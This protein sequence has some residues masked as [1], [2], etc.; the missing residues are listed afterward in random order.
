V[1][2]VAHRW[3]RKSSDES[4]VETSA[5]LNDVLAGLSQAQ[6]PHLFSHLEPVNLPKGKILYE[7]AEPITSVLFVLSGMISLMAT[8]VDG[9]ST[10]VAAV[11]KEGVVGASAI[12]R[13]EKAPYQISVQVQGFGLRVRSEV[14]N[15]EFD[16]GGPLRERLL[17]YIHSLISEISQSAAC[18]RFHSVDQR[19]CRWLLTYADRLGSNSITLTHEALS[20]M[21]GASR[22]NVSQAAAKLRQLQLI[23]YRQCSIQVI[24]RV[25]LEN[26]ACECYRVVSRDLCSQPS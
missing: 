6:Y 14:V 3:Q 13:G 11:G 25:G 12:L 5:V 8:T 1:L 23:D 20:R 26:I 15:S 17:L 10:Q 21:I 24:N 18:N 16:R 7:L 22:T 9:E 4:R 2:E 19:L